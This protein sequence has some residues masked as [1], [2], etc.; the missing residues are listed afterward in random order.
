MI[1]LRN[2]FLGIVIIACVL[3]LSAYLFMQTKP[4]GKLP[5]GEHLTRIQ[6]SQHYLNGEF[7]N[8]S[9][10]ILSTGNKSR[11]RVF[12]DFVFDRIEHLTPPAPLPTVE[13]NLKALPT[14]RNFFVWFGHSSYLIQLDGKRFLIDPVLVAGSPLSFINKMFA[15]SNPYS[16]DEMPEIDYLI[17]THDH[18]D[19]LDYETVSQLMPKVKHVITT[20]GVGSHLEYWGY[21]PKKITELDW[22]QQNPLAA[23]LNI[24][25]LPARHFSGR[26]ITG[27]KTLWASF[28]LQSATETIYIGGDSGYDRFYQD[29]AK[30]FPNISLAIMENG[31]YNVNWAN[32]HIQP[33]ELVQAIKTLKPKKL[34]GVHNSKFALA[35]HSWKEPLEQLYQHSQQ[36]KLPLFTPMIGEVFYFSEDNQHFS[37]WWDNVK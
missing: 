8:L 28:M 2:I 35:K 10:T 24:T 12:Y 3:A 33:H 34:L 29:I 7:K 16:P 5:S 4:F 27:N 17:I 9:P 31:Q 18:W 23:Q 11:W 22:F 30:H 15:G 14:D 36:E 25:A 6:Q 1:L 37:K 26:G 13:I 32:V 20:L 19:H 21:D